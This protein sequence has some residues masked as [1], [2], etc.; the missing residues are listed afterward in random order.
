MAFFDSQT[1]SNPFHMPFGGKY[2]T[3]ENQ[4]YFFLTMFEMI[5]FFELLPNVRPK[6]P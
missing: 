6:C 4:N 5:R 1:I 2:V 3:I